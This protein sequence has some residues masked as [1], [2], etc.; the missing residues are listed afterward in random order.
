MKMIE[1]AIDENDSARFAP[2]AGCRLDLETYERIFDAAPAM[3]MVLDTD[4]RIVRA[5]RT[6]ADRVGARPADLIGRPC[7]RVFHGTDSP[8]ARCPHLKVLKK[9]KTASAEIE[10]KRLG[11]H[12]MVTASPLYDSSHRLVGAVHTA[13]DISARK[14][15]ENAARVADRA[16]RR[17]LAR[18]NHEIRT[19]VHTIIGGVERMLASDPK[20][21]HIEDLENL[22]ASSKYLL[23][24]VNGA[25]DISTPESEEFDP[26][27][28]DF[29]LDILLG[30][31]ERIL[32]HRPGK[33][34]SVRTLNGNDRLP[35]I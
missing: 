23:E 16:K 21:D 18:M 7:C 29:S 32:N 28:P 13:W 26:E 17:H 31:V 2:T 30:Q 27:I 34:A 14:R 19:P 11:G 6:L 3:I 9:E 15:A 10:E 12:F 24:I 1:Q 35:N 4:H 8:P 5:S 20:P 33:K 25:P 22:R